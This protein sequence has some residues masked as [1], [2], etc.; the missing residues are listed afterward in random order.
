MLAWIL[1]FGAIGSVGAVAGSALLLVIPDG[2]RVRLVPGLVSYAAGT[3]LGTAFLVLMPA[4][5]ARAP[6]LPFLATVLGGMVLSFA[7]EKLVLSRHCHEEGCAV[8]GAAAPSIL[9]GDAVHNFADG[10]V[11]AAAFLTSFPLG[12]VT[13]LAVVAH[14]EPQEV[15]DFAILLDSGYGPA[16]AM[17]LNGL[18]ATATLPGA[19]VAWLWFGTVQGALPYML[20]LSAASFIYI[21][22][23]DLIP[24][25]HRQTTASG[26]RRQFALMVTG[27]ATI[28]AFHVPG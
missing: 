11:I 18:S 2:V 4:G 24:G 22:A 8:H 26:S 7:L 23:A 3:L 6:A 13:T 17:L 9:V 12:V 14:E 1:A 28:A 19:V 5:L 10:V 16:K 15:G 21:A 20:A 25:L 27:V